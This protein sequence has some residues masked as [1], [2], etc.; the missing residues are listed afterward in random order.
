MLLKI[1]LSEMGFKQG[2]AMKMYSDNT[3]AIKWA[4]NPIYHKRTKHVEVD[5]R[6]IRENIQSEDVELVYI[7]TNDQAADFL[8]KAVGRKELDG[9]LTKLGIVNIYAMQQ[10]EGEYYQLKD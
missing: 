2:E 1:L 6:Y 10:L 7:S 3:S 9:V 4:K 8:T 5:C